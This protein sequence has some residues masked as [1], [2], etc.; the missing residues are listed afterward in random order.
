MPDKDAVSQSAY[1][2]RVSAG[3]QLLWDPAGSR[4]PEQSVRLC[5]TAAA[6]L[7]GIDIFLQVKDQAGRESLPAEDF[8]YF[9]QEEDWDAPWIAASEDAPRETVYFTRAFEL[10]GNA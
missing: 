4:L 7:G 8:F 10:R 3:K 2:I 9:A 6:S 5:R 1:R